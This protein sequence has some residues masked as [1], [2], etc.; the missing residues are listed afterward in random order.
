MFRRNAAP[1]NKAAAPTAAVCMGTPAVEA[2][3]PAPAVAVAETP[4]VNGTELPLVAPLKAAEV[5]VALGVATVLLGLRTLQISSAISKPHA[6][7]NI[8]KGQKFRDF[9]IKTHLSMT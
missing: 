5:V 6:E 8:A 2:E 9:V 1:P 3:V 4:E 7:E